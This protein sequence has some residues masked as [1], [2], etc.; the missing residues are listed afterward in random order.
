MIAEY[1]G[2]NNAMRRFV[3]GPEGDEPIV[4][5]QLGDTTERRF[6]HAD[7]QGSIIAVTNN[8]GA[9]IGGGN[10]DEYGNPQSGA[11]AGRF[12]YTGQAWLSEI[13]MWYYRARIYNSAL[14]RFMQTDPVGYDGGIN[15][16]A[17]AASDPVNATDPNGT[18]PWWTHHNMID[19]AFPGLTQRQRALLRGASDYADQPEYQTPEN[20]FRHSMR[21]PGE[22]PAQGQ[23]R[24]EQFVAAQSR[25]ARQSQGPVTNARAIN[26]RSLR[27][28]GVGA[29]ARMDATSPMHRDAAGNPIQ[30][31]GGR[32]ELMEHLF[33]ERWSSPQQFSNG[34][35]AL[36]QY[37]GLVYGRD[38]LQQAITRTPNS[39]ENRGSGSETCQ[40]I[41]NSC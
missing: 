10:Y 4:W 18:W 24:T 14:G 2:A 22:T 12:G 9:L 16:Y 29:H 13:G 5:Y 37:F 17:Y 35:N 6:L 15:L 32:V 8:S 39:E 31:N 30:Y 28:F 20:S 41:P 7:Q 23:Q 26:D 3:H 11:I 1:D 36:R 19:S 40:S 33:G 27:Y 34:V 25:A 38:A 21:G